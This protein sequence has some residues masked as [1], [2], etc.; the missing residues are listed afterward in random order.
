MIERDEDGDDVVDPTPIVDVNPDCSDVTD[1]NDLRPQGEPII[2]AVVNSREAYDYFFNSMMMQFGI[3]AS[4]CEPDHSQT[5]YA[6]AKIDGYDIGGE[7]G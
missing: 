5:S 3:P 2:S 7:A 4:W 6:N 1:Y